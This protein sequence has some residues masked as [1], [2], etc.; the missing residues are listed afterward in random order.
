MPEN[1]D[2]QVIKVK[3]IYKDI[4]DCM[5]EVVSPLLLPKENAL[6][7]LLREGRLMPLAYDFEEERQFLKDLRMLQCLK[8]FEVN[9]EINKKI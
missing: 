8:T 1:D 6:L 5:A 9:A 2:P 3:L 4:S 7:N